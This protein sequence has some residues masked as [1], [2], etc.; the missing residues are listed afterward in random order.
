MYQAQ[1]QIVK[2]NITTL[3]NMKSCQTTSVDGWRGLTRQLLCSGSCQLVAF[4]TILIGLVAIGRLVMAGTT[5]WPIPPNHN[6]DTMYNLDA[7]V[8]TGASKHGFKY[9]VGYPAD[10]YDRNDLA[11]PCYAVVGGFT[12]S[13]NTTSMTLSGNTHNKAS[14]NEPG[15]FFRHEWTKWSDGRWLAMGDNSIT[16]ERVI[17]KIVDTTFYPNNKT[18]LIAIDKPVTKVNTGYI[19]L[20]AVVPGVSLD[21]KCTS[22]GSMS[23]SGTTVTGSFTA[24]PDLGKKTY[25]EIWWRVAQNQYGDW[26]VDYF[27]KA[28]SC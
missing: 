25:I 28:V 18:M 24:L 16:R 13:G 11:Y 3:Y 21:L 1:S 17:P 12:I 20:S 15:I 23:P 7:K 8:L 4:A 6:L 14:S 19:C 22:S 26:N 5:L 9:V 2:L 27:K 10:V